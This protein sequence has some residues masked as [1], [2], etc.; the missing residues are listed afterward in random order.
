M[1]PRPGWPIERHRR[2]YTKFHLTGFSPATDSP[3]SRSFCIMI[4]LRPAKIAKFV[5]VTCKLSTTD[6]CQILMVLVFAK[7]GS[8]KVMGAL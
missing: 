1:S 4:Y 2:R 5:A 8:L 6:T 3:G 7:R